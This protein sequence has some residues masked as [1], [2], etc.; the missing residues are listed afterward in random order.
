MNYKQGKWAR[1]IIDLQ[2]DDGSWGYFHTLSAPTP[3]QPITTE[4]ALRRLEILGFSIDDKPIKNAVKYMNNCLHGKM[5]IPDREEKAHNWNIYTEL[6]LATWIRIFTLNN[7][8][9]NSIAEKWRQI[10]SASFADGQYNH[11]KYIH[12]YEKTLGIKLNPKASRLVDFVHFYPISLLTNSLDEKIE[13]NY[14]QYIMEHNSG[15]FYVY[16]KKLSIVP[17][18]FQSKNA[19]RYLRAIELLAKYDNPEC[20]KQLAFVVTWL[21]ENMLRKNEWDMGKESKDGIYFPLS[22]SWRDNE[23]R[24]QDCSYRIGRLMERIENI[25]TK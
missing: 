11:N 9:A 19:S 16:D 1:K 14:F 15:M 20:K 18:T 6:M 3:S 2:H 21:K 25:T 12:S 23:N 4:Q 17:E 24:I 10:V 8:K 5:K 22:D 13:A 7:D